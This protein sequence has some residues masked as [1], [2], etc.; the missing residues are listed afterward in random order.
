MYSFFNKLGLDEL[1]NAIDGF[2]L[3]K[4]FLAVV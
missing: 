4:E 1:P 2:V 3:D